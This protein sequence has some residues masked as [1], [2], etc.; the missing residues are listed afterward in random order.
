MDRR[1][2]RPRQCGPAGPPEH[3]ELPVRRID[4]GDA[5]IWLADATLKGMF[6]MLTG[7]DIREE[8]ADKH[9]EIA[10]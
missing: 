9:A 5:G 8:Y 10:L 7:D 6:K 2:P 4:L 3:L 1:R